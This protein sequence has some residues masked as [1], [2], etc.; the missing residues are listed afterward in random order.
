MADMPRSPL[1][2]RSLHDHPDNRHDASTT[3]ATPPRAARASSIESDTVSTPLSSAPSHSALDAVALPMQPNFTSKMSSQEPAP[4][5]AKRRKITVEEKEQIRLE[6]IAKDKARDEAK[7]QREEERRAKDEEKK[8]K[9]EKAE[10]ERRTKEEAARAKREQREE[11]KRVKEL[12]QSKKEE[13]KLKKERVS[14]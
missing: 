13:E 11:M 3:S 2:K 6:K 5:P 1:G 8:Q 12:E 7:A 9:K 14:S 10:E 4:P